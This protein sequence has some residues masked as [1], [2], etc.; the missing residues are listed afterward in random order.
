ML[1]LCVGEL[2]EG[3]TAPKTQSD[4]WRAGKPLI[5]HYA[6][7]VCVRSYYYYYIYAPDLVVDRQL[8]C[9]RAALQ[10]NHFAR[11]LPLGARARAICQKQRQRPGALRFQF[12]H[13]FG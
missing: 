5:N 3:E 7:I 12:S 6:H 1:L 13:K 10:N 4:V 9:Q 8:N 11:P 2:R